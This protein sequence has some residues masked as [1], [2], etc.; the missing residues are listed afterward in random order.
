MGSASY[1]LHISSD[2]AS[3]YLKT[4]EPTS[5][6]ILDS[7]QVRKGF[8]FVMSCLFE[9]HLS[10][11]AA[12]VGPLEVHISIIVDVLRRAF[13]DWMVDE[14]VFEYACPL[15]EPLQNLSEERSKRWALAWW[16]G[17]L[18]PVGAVEYLLKNC[19]R[20]LSSRR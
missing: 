5:G 12:V 7:Y 13:G 2:V 20:Q 17:R 11:L 1:L 3:T 9:V 19:A 6:G 10:R 15:E 14:D 18:F 4:L 16:L 8:Y